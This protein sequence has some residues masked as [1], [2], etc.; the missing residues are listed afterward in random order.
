MVRNSELI[1]DKVKEIMEQI[2]LEE[3]KRM[4]A[5]LSCFSPLLQKNCFVLGFRH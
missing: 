2:L 3:S 5:L 1:S 4:Y